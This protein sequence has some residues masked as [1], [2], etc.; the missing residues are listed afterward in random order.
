[1]CGRFTQRYTWREIH[2]L[3]GLTGAARNLQAHYNIAPTDT[4]EVVR[5]TDGGATELV[6]MR[7]GLIPYWWKKPLK[8]LPATFNA[9][10]ESVADKPMFREA[11]R[12]HRCI[13]PA[14]GYYEWIAR[15]DG[16][17]PYFI[18]AAD[19]SVLSF[20]GLWE[21]W[22]NPETGEP[23]VSCTIIVTDANALTRPIH[24][25]MPVLLDKVDFA[26]GSAARPV[27]SFSGR[28]R[29]SVYACGR[30]PDASTRLETVM[31]IR[32]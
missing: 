21:R 23:V 13:I 7:W 15:P 5:P 20:A 6:S 32:R 29:R 4:V 24:D 30:C 3:Y 19:G 11:F 16:K 25:R 22:K 10:A 28:P 12:R 17:Q 8:Q 26:L 18:S 31:M 14:S 27:R 1:M 2:D 9:R